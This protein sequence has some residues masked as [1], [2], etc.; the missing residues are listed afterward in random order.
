MSIRLK[1][2]INEEEFDAMPESEREYMS[3]S[4]L[5]KSRKVL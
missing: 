1:N 5:Q 2:S 3:E 4:E